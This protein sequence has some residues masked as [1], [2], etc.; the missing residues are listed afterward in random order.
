[1]VAG[2]SG[3]AGFSEPLSVSIKN[4]EAR[5]VTLATCGNHDCTKHLDPQTLK[6]G[7]VGNA[8]V[9]VNGGYNSYVVIDPSSKATLGCLPLRLG[10][11]PE[12]EVTVAVSRV[13]PCDSD[14]GT[15]QAHGSDWS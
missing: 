1:M 9:E 3:C 5:S 15:G 4:D 11:R 10:H 12:Q 2:L 14:G 6:A 7:Q 8:L 13:V